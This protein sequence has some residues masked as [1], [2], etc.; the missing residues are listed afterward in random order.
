MR[1]A[2]ALLLLFSLV[3]VGVWDL[4]A[5]LKGQNHDTVS[6]IVYDWARRFPLL[7][8]GIGL[9]L[10]HVLAPQIQVLPP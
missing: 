1:Y 4:A 9:L 7:P 6:A 10:G 2:F 8:F 3:A 5:I